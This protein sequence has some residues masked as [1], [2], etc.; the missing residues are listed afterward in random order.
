MVTAHS[1]AGVVVGVPRVRWAALGALLSPGLAL[2]MGCAPGRMVLAER[3]PQ[4]YYQTA[5]PVHDTSRE[6]ARVFASVKQVNYS[7]EYITY[8]FA[9]NAAVTESEARAGNVQS[10]ADSSFVETLSKAGTATIIARS[11]DRVA[12]LTTHHVVFFPPLRLQFYDEGPSAGRAPARPR[13]VASASYRRSEWGVLLPHP[14]RGPF[15]VLARDE[16]NDLALLGMRL[17]EQSDTSRFPALSLDTGDPRR[18]SWGSFVY[19]IGYPHGYPMITRAIV[20]NPNWDGR[21][22]FLTD[23]LWNE[24]ISGGLILAVRGE[25]G[26]L[27]PVGLARASAAEPEVRLQP[28]TT[29]F[30]AATGVSQVYTGTVYIESALRI[31]YGITLSVSMTLATDFLNRH[32]VLLRSRGYR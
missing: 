31:R 18:L 21:G 27:E 17:G 25:S 5:Y 11:G 8:L 30:T 32:Q 24:G 9:E 28:D 12:L 2:A 7:A 14:A 15:E 23:G 13:R 4:A 22:A 3:G 10:R 29:G 16:Q 19:V 26:N 6:L 20:S 1:S